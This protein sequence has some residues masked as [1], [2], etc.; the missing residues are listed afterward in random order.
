MP[1]YSDELLPKRG[2]AV[3]VRC[4]RVDK[5]GGVWGSLPEWGARA[6]AYLPPSKIAE[7]GKEQ[8][9]FLAAARR[10]S[11][12]EFVADI[13]EVEEESDWKFQV[14]LDRRS[15][16]EGTEAETVASWRRAEAAARL[17][18][19]AARKAGIS[20]E[21]GRRAVLYCSYE[22]LAQP[23]SLGGSADCD[24]EELA[25]D[26]QLAAAH[27]LGRLARLPNAA[28]EAARRF[29]AAPKELLAA[30]LELCLARQEMITVSKV[31]EL[32]ALT[33]LAVRRAVASAEALAAPAGCS[34]L[35]VTVVG[36]P[37]YHFATRC[38]EDDRER[39]LTFLE[40]AAAHAQQHLALAP[41]A[42]PPAQRVEQP[43]LVG[44]VDHRAPPAQ[45][46]QQPTLNIGLIGDVAHGKSTLCRAL[47]GKRTQQHSSEQKAHGA[48]IKL[49]Y[50]NCLL[51]RC[52]NPAC[53]PPGNFSTSAVGA[54]LPPCGAC[55]SALEVVRCVSF[56]DCPGHA[57][58]IS[59]MLSGVSAFDAVLLVGAANAPCPSPQAAAHLAAVAASK[60]T[61]L[62]SR[63][64]VIQTKA[65][66]LDQRLLLGQLA[67]RA[68]ATSAALAG[69][70]AEGAP[71][72]PVA[73]HLGLGLDAVAM[74][75]ASLPPRP[76]AEL[77]APACLS[78]LRSF[79]VNLP[80]CK[81]SSQLKGGVVG[82][83]LQRGQLHV[84]DEVELRP[85]KVSF[86][87]DG[88][89]SAEPLRAVVEAIQSGETRQNRAAPGGLVAVQTSLCPSLCADNRQVGSMLGAPGTLPPVWSSLF[90]DH[91]EPVTLPV[92]ASQ[93][94][95]S[96]EEVEPAP[97]LKN[98]DKLR[99]HAGSARVDAEVVR[100]SLRRGKLEAS[101][102][103]PLCAAPESQV[104]V[105]HLRFNVKTQ[106]S[107]LAYSARLV[108]G[109]QCGPPG[110]ELPTSP[111][112]PEPGPPMALDDALLRSR[113]CEELAARRPEVSE[114]GK[115]LGLPPP[116]LEK[117]GGAHCI[118][119]NLR[120]M[121]QQLNRSVP[122]LVS[123][124][125]AAGPLEIAL[126]GQ[127]RD[128]ARIAW[129]PR[130]EKLEAKLAG[131]LRG[132]ARRLVRCATCGGF[133]THTER[134]RDLSHSALELVCHECQARRFVQ[135]PAEAGKALRKAL[136]TQ[137]Q[138]VAASGPNRAPLRPR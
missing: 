69:T 26:P 111:A 134:S 55:G 56:V 18:D 59:T 71:F 54:A 27:V 126:A 67:E 28:E 38:A 131:L 70:V 20:R 46:A 65:D 137:K 74:W 84:G 95:E 79:D 78:C 122:D 12:T 101:L 3:V 104:L 21:E 138:L 119:K 13:I 93:D 15:L 136:E 37:R 73:S 96:E 49:G 72:F 91:L 25:L 51:C 123:F 57:E 48:T 82:G 29:P 85:G 76:A 92:A 39:A 68:A 8:R 109:A 16:R 132:Y 22:R 130:K 105:E 112:E 58:L 128:V 127:Q 94:S 97:G 88:R 30:L 106:G 53:P 108:G 5:E 113:F 77:Q 115:D 98:G 81:A 121:A 47:T 44:D 118:W 2:T 86:E 110:S 33:A 83:S 116:D 35:E 63:L 42:A 114:A 52:T 135:A 90:L 36:P 102:K 14:V 124:L 61:W 66:V 103:W 17:V 6:S 129:R 80:G 11:R 31:V 19:E 99:I 133:A 107:S 40:G 10:N 60:G 100:V 1:L 32:S 75:L 117:E 24:E 9:R 41:P 50:A 45:P 7:K 89:F 23:R 34:S 125:A 120:K 43:T 87:P 4:E 64:A 62:Q